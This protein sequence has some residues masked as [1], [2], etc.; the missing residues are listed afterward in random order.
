MLKS[1]FDKGKS[2]TVL[3]AIEKFGLELEAVLKTSPSIRPETVFADRVVGKPYIEIDI[4][5]QAISRYGLKVTDVQEVLQVALGGR[6]LTR[7]VEGRER[8]PV[9][10]RYMREERDSIEALERIKENRFR[11]PLSTRTLG[12]G[13]GP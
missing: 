10:V 6:T 8:Y 11:E 4:D 12:A 1:H 3:E 13:I 9:R 5:R 7:T 2:L